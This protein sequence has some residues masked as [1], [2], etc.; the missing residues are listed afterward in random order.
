VRLPHWEKSADAI[1][2]RLIRQAG[3]EKGTN[4]K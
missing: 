2:E 1:V 4:S 3:R